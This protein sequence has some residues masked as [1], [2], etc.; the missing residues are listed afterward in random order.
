ME[1]A[2]PS[3]MYGPS[4]NTGQVI[5]EEVFAASG[6]RDPNYVSRRR[7]RYIY[8]LGMATVFSMLLL[9]CYMLLTEQYLEGLIAVLLLMGILLGT[10]DTIFARHAIAAVNYA[11]P[12]LFII[13]VAVLG[14]I[15]GAYSDRHTIIKYNFMPVDRAKLL[16]EPTSADVLDMDTSI[17]IT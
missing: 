16:D 4:N 8:V 11:R 17:N 15:I 5:E 7:N 1:L 9:V 3:E 13:S 14:Y 10:Y 2:S 12:F 6:A